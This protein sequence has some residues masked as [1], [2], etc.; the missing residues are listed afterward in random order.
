[1]S[2]CIYCGNSLG[3]G[4]TVCPRCQ[5]SQISPGSTSRPANYESNQELQEKRE[6][7]V[8]R[9]NTVD[10]IAVILSLLVGTIKAMFGGK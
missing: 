2:K 10:W 4:A 3:D 8:R 6:R 7:D 1:M 9:G 5:N